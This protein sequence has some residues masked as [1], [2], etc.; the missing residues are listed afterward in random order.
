MLSES[1]YLL[2]WDEYG[3]VKL[4]EGEELELR[5]DSDGMLAEGALWL[6]KGS[7]KVGY[8]P[9]KQGRAILDAVGPGAYV[10]AVVELAGDSQ[11][12]ICPV[13]YFSDL[14]ARRA[15]EEEHERKDSEFKLKA[16]GC[17]GIALV[18]FAILV[19]ALL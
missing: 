1:I 2:S 9:A 10:T 8:V 4:E 19:V 14:E 13:V 15:R 17:L 6:L 12:G 5:P 18:V 11:A 7:R 16:L 3:H